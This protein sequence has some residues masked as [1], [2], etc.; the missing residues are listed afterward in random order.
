MV[1]EITDTNQTPEET[2][3]LN[4]PIHDSH[5]L[6]LERLARWSWILGSITIVMG[7]LNLLTLFT[8]EGNILWLIPVMLFSLF[9]I[10]LGTRLT[11]A[12]AFLRQSFQ[13][14]DSRDFLTAMDEFY[15]YFFLVALLYIVAFVFVIVGMVIVAAL[16]NAVNEFAVL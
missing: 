8:F 6:R 5:L 3:V 1:D 4:I 11:A 10:Y 12:T 13:T 9:F 15:K 14:R 16:G 2:P 7:L